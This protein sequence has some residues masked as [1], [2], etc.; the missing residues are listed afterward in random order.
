MGCTYKYVNGGPG[1]P[2]FVY[3]RADWQD[4]LRQPIWGWFGQADQFAMGPGYAPASGI[5]RFATGTP[6][7]LGVAA[8]SEG[9]DL[10]GEAGMPALRAK[11]TALTELMIALYD[12]WLSP[13]GFGLASPRDPMVRAGHVSL[14][15]I[16]RPTRRARP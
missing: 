5:R 10:L 2:A 16:P 7:M 14:A 3:V 13:L 12:A 1:A 4:R 6:P 15:R 8:V 9:V 11:S